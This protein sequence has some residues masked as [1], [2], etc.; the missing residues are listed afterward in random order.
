VKW[1]PGPTAARLAMPLVTGLAATWRLEVL[2]ADR[3]AA[4]PRGA[5][6]V[7]LLWHETLL[8]L[9]WAHRHMGVH[10]L[11]SEARDGRYLMDYAGRLGYGTIAGSVTRGG[12]KA[13]FRALKELKAGAT[14]AFATDGPRG[15][16][17]QVK[18]GG[19]LMA[20]RAGCVVIPVFAGARAAWRLKS[21]DRFLVPK[22]FARVRVVYGHPLRLDPQDP[23]V[24]AGVKEVEAQLA[25]LE[26]EIAW[27]SGAGAPTD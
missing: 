9:L 14:V 1:K 4:A 13:M 3:L 8:P 25:Q 17:R 18:P 23:E 5:P 19:L 10:I 22:P 20:T 11:A 7:I 24:N 21:W 27:P 12:L 26:R 15:P 6:R 16:R 2:H